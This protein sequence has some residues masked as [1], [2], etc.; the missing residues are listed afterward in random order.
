MATEIVNLEVKSDIKGVVVDV[1]ALAT[2]LKQAELDYVNLNTQV[3]I[4][5]D[6][7]IKLEK[8]LINLKALQVTTPRTASAGYP[9]LIKKIKETTTEIALEKNGLKDLNNQRADSK[10][11][12]DKNVR[13][14]GN[15][16]KASKG[17]QKGFN[18]LKTGARGFGLALKAMGIGLI[19]SALM[20]LRNA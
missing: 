11:L 14:L 6:V 9:Q 18:L 7:V 5:K 2:S 16:Q 20:F 13:S 1:N 8:E 4:Q 10:I 15:L 12:L 3:K 17:G 19:I